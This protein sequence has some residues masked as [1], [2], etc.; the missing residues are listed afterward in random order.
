HLEFKNA[1]VVSCE[2]QGNHFRVT[3]LWEGHTIMAHT[4]D[5]PRSQ[6]VRL[7]VR[8]SQMREF[9]NGQLVTK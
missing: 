7:S 1:Q 4:S 2:F 6:I 8:I 9:L 5:R 3:L